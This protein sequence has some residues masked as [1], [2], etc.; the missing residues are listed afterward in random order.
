MAVHAYTF[1][2]VPEDIRGYQVWPGSAERR[3]ID[4]GR[5]TSAD[6]PRLAMAIEAL[7]PGDTLLVYALDRLGPTGLTVLEVIARVMGKGATLQAVDDDITVSPE[8]ALRAVALCAALA[9]I[10]TR[11]DN[12]PELVKGPQPARRKSHAGRPQ[13]LTPDQISHARQS[14]DSGQQSVSS[15]ARLLKVNKTT[16]W[17]ALRDMGPG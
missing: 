15:M 11:H 17:R 13:S 14:I 16:L 5:D 3:W 4:C 8:D 7:E 9:S 12:E 6:R 1:A 2:S 10:D